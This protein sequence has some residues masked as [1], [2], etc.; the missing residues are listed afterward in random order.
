MHYPDFGRARQYALQR[1]KQELASTLYYHSVAHTR[2]EVVPAAER[3]A[4]MQGV[5]GEPRLLLLTAAFYHDIGFVEQGNGHETISVRIAE[6]SLPGFGYKPGQIQ[7][8]RGIIMATDRSRPP[9]TH[10]EA[11]LADAD[12]DVL[13]SDEYVSRSHDLRMEL[14]AEGQLMSD[15]QWYRHQIQFLGEHHY[16][17]VSARVLRDEG[18][19]RNIE[20]LGVLIEECPPTT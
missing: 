11:I 4:I 14:E 12:L 16:W 20:R 17:T 3:L 6:R 7:L 1:L 19:Q 5:A 2:D 8:I 18:I 13:G 9:S 10:L 15:C